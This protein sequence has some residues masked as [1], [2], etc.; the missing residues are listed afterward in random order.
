[1]AGTQLPRAPAGLRPR[2][3]A[4]WREVHRDYMLDAVECELLTELCRVVDRCDQ[5]QTE[6]EGQPLMTSGSVGQ[7]RVTPLL[8][9]LQNQQKL[10]DRLASSLGVS[11]PNQAGATR[12]SGPKRKAAQVRWSRST[13]ASVIP[14]RGA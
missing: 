2:G 13:K 10:A 3:K 6:L 5:I 1:M 7:P 14:M 9:A 4:L 8:T 12:G 11:M